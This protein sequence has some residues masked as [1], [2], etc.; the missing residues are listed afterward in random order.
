LLPKL[1]VCAGGTFA[2]STAVTIGFA[3]PTTLRA[4]TASTA[5]I[6]LSTALSA[7]IAQ[8]NWDNYVLSHICVL[9]ELLNL[10]FL[11]LLKY[12]EFQSKQPI[13]PQ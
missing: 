6:L 9:N 12:N 10:G 3:P 1:A 4:K 13:L 2:F 5:V 11:S 7:Q 8:L